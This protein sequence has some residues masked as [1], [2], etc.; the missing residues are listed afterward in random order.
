MFYFVYYASC[1]ACILPVCCVY[2]IVYVLYSFTNYIVYC[3][4]PTVLCMCVWL[5]VVSPMLSSTYSSFPSD[6]TLSKCFHWRHLL[7][8]LGG[9]ILKKPDAQY[10]EPQGCLRV[11]LESALSLNFCCSNIMGHAEPH[12]LPANAG[13]TLATF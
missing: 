12:M 7:C 3:G 2:F 11:C 1:A 6:Q 5:R 9:L 4:V 8:L 13:A 10:Y